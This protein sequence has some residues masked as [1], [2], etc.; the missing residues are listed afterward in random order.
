MRTRFRKFLAALVLLSGPA[1][2][3]L[4]SQLGSDITPIRSV[5]DPF[6]TFTDVAVDPESNLLAVT[7]EN[8]FSIRTYDRDLQSNAVA[9]PRTVISGN[10]TGIDFVCGVALDPRNKEIY[11]VN[12]DTAA[13]LM[14][15]KYDSNGNVPRSRSLRPA[16]ATTWG[17]SLDLTNNELAVTVEQANKLA[18]YR[19]LAEDD[20]KPL[21]I[22]QGPN[23]GLADPHGVFIDAQNNEIVVANHD[24]YHEP[25][26]DQD[27]VDTVQAQLAR[28]VPAPVVPPERRAP[29]PSKGKFVAPSITVYSRTA[30]DD[31]A[32]LRIISGPRTEL[33]LPM[34]VFV[35]MAH[36]ELFVA[37][38]GT[39]AILVF[40]RTANGNV[41]PIRKI[42]GPATGLKKPVGLFVDTKNDEVWAT[43]P[44]QHAAT[45]YRR[46]A[47]GN[48]APLRV[49]RGAPEGTPAPGI[50]NPGGIAYD[51]TREQILV[52]N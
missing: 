2:L 32:P 17:V 52:P 43:S 11:A 6:P 38:S 33:S 39:S 16:S 14:V 42:Q 26:A 25:T 7:D 40:N 10:K 19:R 50:G 24:S 35:D 13:D 34:K 18:I 12:N 29:R 3:Y 45:V 5:R 15:F 27:G 28:G 37:N 51:P 46:T 47:Q 9:D 31:A 41:A 44:E 20:E 1:V 23:T 4:F 48:A 49:L 36:N 30:H 22:I 21:R 8:L